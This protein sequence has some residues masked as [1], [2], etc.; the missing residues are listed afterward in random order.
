MV[1]MTLTK[2]NEKMILQIKNGTS[3]LKSG[4]SKMKAVQFQGIFFINF[5][6]AQL[7]LFSVEINFH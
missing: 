4:N 6:V 5:A 3:K 1:L 7:R 2:K